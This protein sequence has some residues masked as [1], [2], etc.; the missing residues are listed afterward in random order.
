MVGASGSVYIGVQYFR[1]RVDLTSKKNPLHNDKDGLY[2][3]KII[4]KEVKVHLT[5]KI[6]FR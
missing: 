4:L 1:Y 5:P 3:K 2:V 6:F